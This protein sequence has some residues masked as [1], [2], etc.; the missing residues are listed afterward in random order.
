MGDRLYRASIDQELCI[1]CGLCEETMPDVFRLGAYTASVAIE[2]VSEDRLA[3]LEIAARDCPVDAISIHEYGPAG[4]SGDAPGDHDHEG[5][6]VEEGGEIGEYK[7]KHGYIA[8]RDEV[9]PD[10]AQR[11]ERGKHN[12]SI[13]RNGTNDN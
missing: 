13:V 6:D 12:F 2:F 7:R 5:E 9:E 10:H 8:N 11:L 3:A 4:V 1:G